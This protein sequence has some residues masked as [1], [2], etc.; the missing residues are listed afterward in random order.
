MELVRPHPSPNSAAFDPAFVKAH[1]LRYSGPVKKLPRRLLVKIFQ[2]VPLEDLTVLLSVNKLFRSTLLDNYRLILFYPHIIT[3]RYELCPLTFTFPIDWADS[4]SASF[5]NALHRVLMYEDCFHITAEVLADGYIK[6]WKNAAERNPRLKASLSEL[7]D[8]MD[9]E[10]L[11]DDILARLV[12]S[13]WKRRVLKVE[14][15]IN[16]TLSL[17]PEGYL[18]VALGGCDNLKSKWANGMPD[19]AISE[20]SRT[21]LSDD[22]NEG[23]FQDPDVN[24]EPILMGKN[25]LRQAIKY[26]IHHNI[27]EELSYSYPSLKLERLHPVQILE[28]MRIRIPTWSW[29]QEDQVEK[30]RK[31]FMD[32]PAA[33]DEMEK[34]REEWEIMRVKIEHVV[35]ATPF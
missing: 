23:L 5:Y 1:M 13:V 29:R 30:L 19:I 7:L 11:K 3:T 8:C 27:R 21:S 16:F 4:L 24:I 33:V 28:F 17:A 18:H 32:S 9:W 34:C 31:Q 14:E 20:S 6:F 25:L 2:Q 26:S 10:D 15:A 12:R 22:S 35:N